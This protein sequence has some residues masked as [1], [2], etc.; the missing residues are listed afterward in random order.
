M[1]KYY[2]E[3][4]LFCI[5]DKNHPYNLTLAPCIRSAFNHKYNKIEL[6]KKMNIFV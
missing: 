6:L 2:Y 1:K 5:F 3:K 4:K